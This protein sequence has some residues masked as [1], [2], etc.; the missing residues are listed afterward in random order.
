VYKHAEIASMLGIAQGTSKSQLHRVRMILR[1]F[2]D[3]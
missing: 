3:A 1:K 2:L